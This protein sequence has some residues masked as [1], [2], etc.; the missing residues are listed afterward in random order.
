[1][2][3][4]TVG[5]QARQ[6]NLLSQHTILESALSDL[7]MPLTVLRPAWFLDNLAW[8]VASARDE[9]VIHSFLQPLDRK[10]PMVATGDIGETA[11]RLI[12]QEWIGRRIVELEG[13]VRISP[14][15]IAAL[16][17][18]ILG[19]PVR[20]EAVSRE[21]WASLFLSQG[22]RD[23]VPRIQMLDGFNEG[24]IDFEGPDGSVL[25][26]SIDARAAIEKLVN[27]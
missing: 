10:I 27:A 23:P 16:F 24:W 5:A 12:Q 17:A 21:S 4:S 1:V 15:E 22:M 20:V 11:A 8:D 6:T 2:S 3:I 9:G 26:G 18:D 7:S 14:T 13:P 25:K 19:R